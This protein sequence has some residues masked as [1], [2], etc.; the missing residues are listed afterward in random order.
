[1]DRPSA[2]P[3]VESVTVITASGNPMRSIFPAAIRAGGVAMRNKA[4]LMLD[5]PALSESTA[6][7]AVPALDIDAS[8]R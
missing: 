8:A 3:V 5:D 4:N 2:R 6:G 7:C 1:M